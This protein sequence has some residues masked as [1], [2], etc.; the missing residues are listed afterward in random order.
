[1]PFSIEPGPIEG[2]FLI[3]PKVFGDERGYFLETWSDKDYA[4]AGLDARFVQDNQS[5]SRKGV[6][7]GLHFQ[8]RY[9]QGKLVRAI[10]GEIFDVAVDLRP[11]SA[12]FGKWHGM[13]LSGK[14]QNQFYVPPGFAHGFLVLSDEAVFAYKCTDFYHP[15]D[16]GGVRWDDPAIGI[17]WPE[18]GFP[19]IL[20]D[21]DSALPGL[22]DVASQNVRPSSSIQTQNIR[23][24]DHIVMLVEVPNGLN[25]P[26]CD[27]EGRFWIKNGADKRKVT[28]PEELQRLFQ[29]GAKLFADERPVPDTSVDD[30]DMSEF[31]DFYLRKTGSRLDTATLSTGRILEALGFMKKGSITLAGL[32]LLGKDLSRH[33]PLF[34]I[35]AASFPGTGLSDD[36][37][38]DKVELK[39]RLPE[40]FAAAMNFLDRNLRHV[41]ANPALGFNQVGVLEVSREALQ[42]VLVNALVHRDYLINASIKLFVFSDRVEIMSPGILPNSLSIE[43]VRLGVSV[44]RNSVLLSHA[45]YVMPY[46]G[47]GSGLPRSLARCPDMELVNDEKANR[48]VVRFPR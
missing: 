17:E 27:N 4:D 43:A 19:P 22:N 12:T 3:Q 28:S 2:L 38:L 41:Q 7:R 42:E 10:Q 46:S 39:G 36:A 18:L 11:G 48:F 40:Q 13:I 26:Y 25:K 1:M 30:L 44:P 33:A 6:L 5:L 15:E 34:H 47:L 21:R 45:Q 14:V 23:I 37:F 29:A 35:A 24:D 31:A 32:L 8:R 20:S 16:E 9:P